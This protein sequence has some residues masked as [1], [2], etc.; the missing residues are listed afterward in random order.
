MRVLL[1][2]LILLLS[3]LLFIQSD[4]GQQ[5]LTRKAKSILEDQFQT[6][7]ELQRI[8]LNGFNRVSVE[9]LTV[10]DQQ[11][12]LLIH[13]G[14]LSLHFALFPLFSN[15]MLVH[16]LEWKELTASV[17]TL[18]N[19]KLNYQFLIDGFNSAG[20]DTMKIEQP[21]KKAWKLSL[22]R[23]EFNNI[24]ILYDD[25]PAGLYTALVLKRLS[26]RFRET[27]IQG[28]TYDFNDLRISGLKGFY[29]QQYR[30]KD[31]G[32]KAADR[33]ATNPFKLQVKGKL[34]QL[35]EIDFAYQD[36]GG[37][38]HTGWQLNQGRIE[39]LNADVGENKYLS[40]N[41]RLVSPK[42][43][44]I[45]QKGLD[46]LEVSS[47]STQPLQVTVQ[48]LDLKDGAFGMQN[49]Q[50]KRIPYPHSIDFNYPGLSA[51]E[52]DI[53][54]IDWKE[55]RLS[56]VLANLS[57]KE[58][59]GFRLT[60]AS[61]KL[62]YGNQR[63]SLTD[64]SIQTG[65][66]QLSNSI[67]LHFPS[68]QQGDIKTDQIGVQAQ[69]AAS[70]LA[71][72]EVLFFVPE[73]KQ[74]TNFRK[75]WD[76]EIRLNGKVSGN[77]SA[78]QLQAFHIQD[79]AGNDIHL[80]GLVRSLTVPDKLG[81]EL[82]SLS[83]ETGKS[84][85]TSWISE[86]LL[87]ANLE[88]PERL[89]LLGRLS[90]NINNLNAALTLNSSYGLIRFKGRVNGIKQTSTARYELD[91]QELNMNIGQWIRD[92]SL[93]LIV[94]TGKLK[95]QG[96][97]PE[98]M[99]SEAAVRIQEANIKGYNYQQID[100]TGSLNQQKYT[101]YIYSLDTNLQTQVKLTGV[102]TDGYP[103][104]NGK[105][106]VNRADLQ[107]I[108]LSTSPF[109]VKGEIDLDLKDTRPRKLD[110]TVFVHHVQYANEQDL[111]QLDSLAILARAE[112]DSQHIKVEGPIGFLSLD[113][114]Y[115]YTQLATAVSNLI[116]RQLNH[117]DSL[118]IVKTD[119]IASQSARLT[120]SLILPR[121]MEKLLPD[122]QI[123]QPL[124]LEG[125]MNTDSSL[126][127]LEAAHPQFRY[128]TAIVDSFRLKLFFDEDTVHTS[129]QVAQIEHPAFPVYNMA[130]TA[131]GKPGNI[132]WL[133]AVDDAQKKPSYRVG[134]NWQGSSRS[135]WNLGLDPEIV[136]NKE[137]FT[138]VADSAIVF[139]KG[140]LWDAAFEIR[141]DS[142]SV[143][144]DH[145]RLD[146][147][148]NIA[149]QLLI[150][151]FE[152]RTM[153]AFISKDT[154][155]AEGTINA[156]LQLNQT[157]TDSSI[158]GT[159]S[160]DS[161]RL[162]GKPVG[163]LSAELTKDGA[164][165][166]VLA[167]LEGYGNNVKMEGSYSDRINATLRFD[168]LQLASIEPF[169]AGATTNMSGALTG[170]LD[171]SG[172]LTNP[173]INGSLVFH[174]GKLR[175]SYLNNPLEIDQQELMFT[176]RT[177]LLNQFTLTDTAGGKATMNGRIK[178]ENLLNPGFDL[179]VDA[180]NFLVLG[181]KN[182]AEQMI[183]GP[184][185]INS[186]ISIK[187]DLSLPRVDMQ[188]KLMDKSAIGFVVPDEEPGIANRE[189][190][191]EFVNRQSPPDSTLL[192]QSEKN[193][194]TA[195]GFTGIEFSGDLELTPASTLTIVIDPYNGDFL[196]VK[197]S[198]SLNVKIEQGNRMSIT[199]VY[200]IEGGK[201]EM[202]LNQLIKRSFSIE[203]GSTITWNGDP[204]EAAIN[205]RAKYQ[206]DAPAID[207]IRDQSSGSRTELTRL[208]QKVP[209]DVYMNIRDKLMQPDISF[210]LDMPEKDRNFFNGAV[211]TRL[212]QIN[213]NESE[214][215]KQVM[216]LLVLQ[217]FL[218]ENPL[219]S[220]ENRSG[221]GIGLAA[222][223]SVSK[224]LSQQLNSLAGTLISGIDLNFDLET[225]EDY[226]SGSRQESTVLNIGASKTLFNDRLTVSVGSN[227]GVLGN[228]PSN[229]AQ[230]IGDVLI[231]YK[232][233][234]DGRYRIRAYQRNQTDAIL[235]GQIIETGVSFILVMDFDQFRQIFER[236]K[237]HQENARNSK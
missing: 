100:I 42:G 87:P 105:L 198:A 196:E 230:L 220:L 207:L 85:I 132:N 60:K 113:G 222:K 233:S 114:N 89:E 126:L 150:K 90:G 153:S 203:K 226:M 217:T 123:R 166:G 182:S 93:G 21:T 193:P 210:E 61:G 37:G 82:S 173:D 200:E 107:A 83:I 127:Y 205:I 53:T 74:D 234:R 147:S 46:T 40:G 155:L 139:R 134:G 70:R 22:G 71:L 187:G 34:I 86:S 49:L 111:I 68:N 211:Y 131:K 11:N 3:L 154:T 118:S 189:G 179:G 23:M 140:Q 229:G 31:S 145:I 8:R 142:Q 186:T 102:L 78:L 218:S 101:A 228:A 18:A 56:A 141:S 51:I 36:Q 77:L 62:A 119:S 151:D 130:V 225:R 47:G 120:A 178:M 84:A 39:L 27:D 80:T 95:G 174:K 117:A 237:K 110:G 190:V 195:T 99:N 115:D 2:L 67:E 181:P 106:T 6:R 235:L 44:L 98:T 73:L 161:L 116:K 66:S 122:L 104:F 129:I 146:S 13:S 157:I 232:L 30:E 227:I 180:K 16:S 135:D 204:L 103:S 175:V 55:N 136:L 121:S 194:G 45:R 112:L 108:G 208:R 19:K 168:S 41:I 63:L 199:G 137:R 7:V 26:W 57:A 170:N 28:G 206:V 88:L 94:A 160:V 183:W 224:I 24:R 159:V 192:F 148:K 191:I 164:N 169:T 32:Q 48:S 202:S 10:F 17:Y 97:N 9:G 96:F 81:A 52:T 38:I 209:V 69:L 25:Q 213:N 177:L 231:E 133:L 138:T 156:R 219:E 236:A 72:R 58:R 162:F 172:E 125:S 92:T 176:N 50:E 20:K 185:S 188:L 215:T 184:A 144:L 91:L 12:H 221:G 33:T 4:W 149:Y 223:Q 29:A 59:S 124:T 79:N 75:W 216:A 14:E 1:S 35:E 64:Y 109:I 163:N 54:S 165:V 128:T 197:G 212:K 143:K 76:K 65:S 167:T 43:Y 214:L 152:A 5:L 171:I 201:Y 158:T 15:K